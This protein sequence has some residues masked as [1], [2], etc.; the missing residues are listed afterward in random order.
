MQQGLLINAFI[1]LLY[2]YGCLRNE[3]AYTAKALYWLRELKPERNVLQSGW[4]RL[5]FNPVHAADGQ[6]LLE[7]KQEYCN[8]RRCLDCAIDV[9]YLNRNKGLDGQP[10]RESSRK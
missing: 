4:Q 3:P 5:G 9:P 8:K 1:P 6:A 10:L 2:A 7:L